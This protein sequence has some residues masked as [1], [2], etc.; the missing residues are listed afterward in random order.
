MNRK[1]INLSEIMLSTDLSFNLEIFVEMH[2]LISRWF[3]QSKWIVH[4]SL[5]TPFKLEANRKTKLFGSKFK[6]LS[7]YMNWLHSIKCT[8]FLCHISVTFVQSNVN[9]IL[10]K[11]QIRAG[12]KQS[13]SKDNKEIPISRGKIVIKFNLFCH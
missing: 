4:C 12:I 10:K 11:T 3:I 1:S 9:W 2:P 8:F 13:K 5:D 7:S 6:P